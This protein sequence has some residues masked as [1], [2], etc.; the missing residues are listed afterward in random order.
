MQPA[1][2]CISVGYKMNR[3]IERAKSTYI[4]FSKTCPLHKIKLYNI[5]QNKRPIFCYLN[6]FGA[7]LKHDPM[8]LVLIVD[9]AGGVQAGGGGRRRDVTGKPRGSGG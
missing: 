1:R 4:P 3:K 8:K 2:K 6:G 7:V 9:W 5:D